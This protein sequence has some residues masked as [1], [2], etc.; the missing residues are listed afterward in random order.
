V[1]FFEKQAKDN[2]RTLLG[3]LGQAMPKETKSEIDVGPTLE[4]LV[5]LAA[6][7]REERDAAAKKGV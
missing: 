4:Q 3:L 6:R 2:P 1:G 7:R 5:L